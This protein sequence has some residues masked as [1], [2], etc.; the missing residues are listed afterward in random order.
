[1]ES[2][3]SNRITSR[4]DLEKTMVVIKHARGKSQ[5]VV[6]ASDP[7]EKQSGE[8]FVNVAPVENPEEV[9][10]ISLLVYGIAD[11]QPNSLYWLERIHTTD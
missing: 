4:Y 2:D 5:K 10:V 8:W 7:Y 6:L 9:T 3:M 1:M 11:V